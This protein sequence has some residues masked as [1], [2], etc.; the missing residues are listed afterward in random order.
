MICPRCKRGIKVKVNSPKAII[1]CG[2]CGYAFEYR[3]AVENWWR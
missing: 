1:V 2:Y 3:R